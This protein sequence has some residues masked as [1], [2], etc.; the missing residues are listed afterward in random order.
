MRTHINGDI[1]ISHLLFGFLCLKHLAQIYIL[2]A[3]LSGNQTQ[4]N[5]GGDIVSCCQKVS[6]CIAGDTSLFFDLLHIVHC[7]LQLTDAAVVILEDLTARSKEKRATEYACAPHLE[8]KIYRVKPIPPTTH[9]L[10]QQHELDQRSF[11]GTVPL[12]ATDFRTLPTMWAVI[13]TCDKFR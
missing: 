3:H 13:L 6:I 7:M 4:R 8:A 1:D 10:S 5:K 2:L 11:W 12:L 9:L